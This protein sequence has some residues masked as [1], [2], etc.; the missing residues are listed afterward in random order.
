M[1][2]I[3]LA[4]QLRRRKAAGLVIALLLIIAIALIDR[5]G[6]A[7]PVGDDWHRYHDK[8]FEVVRVIDGDTLDLRIADGER[9][10]TRVRLWGVDTPE[11]ARPGRD[12]PSEPFAEEAAALAREL[13]EGRRV[14]LYLQ[15]HRVRG[16]YGRLLA[17][18]ELPDG[19]VLNAE[20]IE[21]GLSEHDDRW[22]HD[23]SEAYEQLEQR[24]RAQRRGLWSD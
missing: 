1:N 18:V 24:A 11:L 16:R 19:R 9:Q 15:E 6:G 23:R 17:Y 12:G 20:L 21:Q 14:R 8:S 2:P 22:S 5:L 7:L 4:R 3:A 13:A 10:T